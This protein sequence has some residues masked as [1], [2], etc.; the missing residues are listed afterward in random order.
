MKKMLLGCSMVLGLITGIAI[1]Q[2]AP[3]DD[4]LN[5]IHQDPIAVDASRLSLHPQS[6]FIIA[7][8]ST[9]GSW[10]NLEE[11]NDNYVAAIPRL[12]VKNN[13]LLT[14][15]KFAQP[16]GPGEIIKACH[17]FPTIKPGEKSI[18][19]ASSSDNEITCTISS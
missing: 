13:A 1:A 9:T 4:G 11:T 2:P 16:S 10:Y 6:V 12:T 17:T 3:M 5:I 15:V 18:V 14:Q 7:P 8:G 19:L